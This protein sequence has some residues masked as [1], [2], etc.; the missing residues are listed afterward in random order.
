MPHVVHHA[1][2]GQFYFLVMFPSSKKNFGWLLLLTNNKLNNKTLKNMFV[3]VILMS[4]TLQTLPSFQQ[5]L[6]QQYT[7]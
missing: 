2:K 5:P 6:L 1:V 3:F 7:S 4:H